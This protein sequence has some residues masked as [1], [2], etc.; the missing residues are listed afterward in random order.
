MQTSPHSTL[1]ASIIDTDELRTRLAASRPPR[2]AEI[3][4]PQSFA[5]GHLPGAVNLPLEGF[6][7]NAPRL[8]P[9]KSAE[10]VVYCASETCQNSAMAERKLRELGYANVRVYQGG[11]AAWKAAGLRLE[12]SAEPNVSP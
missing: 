1:A 3:L 7:G 4:G 8:L 2:V 11:K 9:D 12:A 6:T 5:S 10:I